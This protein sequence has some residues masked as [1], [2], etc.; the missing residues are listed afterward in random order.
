MRS[1]LTTLILFTISLEVFGLSVV[2]P[3]IKGDP[4]SRTGK[5]DNEAVRCILWEDT[6]N[7]GSVSGELI[8]AGEFLEPEL[9]I[10]LA[11]WD[12]KGALV[13]SWSI[14]GSEK[15][16]KIHYYFALK[17]DLINTA[18]FDLFAKKEG[19]MELYLNTVRITKK[20]KG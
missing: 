17:S 3:Q 11:A 8:V 10:N 4:K 9:G 5:T 15:E 12:E 13:A 18:K 19:M 14:S 20:D 16:G 7:L 6:T 2:S 1:L